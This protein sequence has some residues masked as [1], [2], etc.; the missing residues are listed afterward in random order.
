MSELIE[1]ILD[2]PVAERIG[3]ARDILDSVVSEP[4]TVQ[5]SPAQLA[6]INRR[7]E[8]NR[9][10]PDKVIPLEEFLADFDRL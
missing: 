1:Q 9:Q 6:E 7:I 8:Y 2:L 4:E 5:V 10:N 3:L